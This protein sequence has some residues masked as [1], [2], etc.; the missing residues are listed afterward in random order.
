MYYFVR[1]RSALAFVCALACL[2]FFYATSTPLRRVVAQEE[3]RVAERRRPAQSGPDDVPAGLRAAIEKTRADEGR[4]ARLEA[5]DASAQYSSAIDPFVQQQRLQASDAAAGDIFGFTVSV[6]GETA[7]VGAYLDNNSGGS[8]AGSA[9]VFV[10]SNG[11]WSQQQ[12]LRASDAAS[13]DIFGTSVCVSGDTIIVGADGNDNSG[14]ID[15]GAAYVFTRSN[16]VWTQQQRLQA[17]DAAPGDGFGSASSVSGETLIVGAGGDDNSGGTDAGSAY[18]FTRSNGV[19]TE[20]QRLQ[21]S[22]SSGDRFGNVVSVS[23]E[24]AIVGAYL[25]DNSGGTDAGSV[26][27]FVRSGATWTEQQ[28]LQASGA[29]SGDIFGASVSLSGDT[30]IAGSYLDTHTGGQAAGSAYIFTR[31]NGVWTEQQR[32]QASDASSGDLFGNAVSV[33]GD[34]AVVGADEDDHSG[35]QGAGSA[36][37]FTRSN[38]MWTEQQRLQASDPASGDVFSRAVSVSG[39]TIFVGADGNDNGGGANAG[40][41][42]V[43]VKGTDVWGRQEQLHPPQSISGAAFGNAVAIN[44]DTAIV[45]AWEHDNNDVGVGTGYFFTRCAG[46]W[47]LQQRVQVTE[48]DGA[49]F[50]SV[51]L[52]GNTAIFGS[53]GSDRTA[54]VVYVFTRSGGVWTQQQR[55]QASDATGTPVMGNG[56][57][58]DFF[59]TSVSVSGDTAIVGAHEDDNSGGTDAGSAYVFTRS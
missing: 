25:D 47:S 13:G 9:Y 24:T 22:A 41:A 34:I 28:R 23:G 11:V 44:G 48:A 39:E 10:R 2:F 56:Q 27:V 33:S 15:S 49:A 3:R 4:G 1:S 6:D 38:G 18:I 32:L 46:V 8:D 55:L 43:F 29:S 57:G 31:S 17:P 19:W 26:Y 58:G 14:G 50:Q 21:S 40:A 45:V 37:V 42:Y 51:A 53:P 12:Q 52:D 36:Y 59:G 7:I 20:Q 54:G 30:L 16:G 5:D 35:G